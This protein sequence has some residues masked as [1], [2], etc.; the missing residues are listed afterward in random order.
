MWHYIGRKTK[1][2]LMHRLPPPLTF[3]PFV[4]ASLK[5]Y[6]L[7]PR[8]EGGTDSY[9]ANKDADV[10]KKLGTEQMRSSLSQSY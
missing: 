8:K 9:Y 6:A 5:E 7:V 4:S 1:L 10:L 2:Y 3:F